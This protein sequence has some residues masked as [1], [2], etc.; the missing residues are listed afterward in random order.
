MPLES[1]LG[2]GY[3]W[4]IREKAER[5]DMFG[6]SL[7]NPARGSDMSSLTGVFCGRIDLRIYGRKDVP[8]KRIFAKIIQGIVKRLRI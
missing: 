6:Q 8:R 4:L 3:V 7:W 2:A 1:D 5:P